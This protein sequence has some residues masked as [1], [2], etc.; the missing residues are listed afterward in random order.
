GGE[1]R[2]TPVRG[3]AGDVD[4]LDPKVDVA[5]VIEGHSPGEHGRAGAAL[6]VSGREG[7]E[8]HVRYQAIGG[9]VVAAHAHGVHQAVV[10]LLVLQELGDV[11]RLQEGAAVHEGHGRGVVGG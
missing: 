8:T 7:H 4:E 10:G 6:D 11:R 5:L 3:V 1:A 2:A 9:E